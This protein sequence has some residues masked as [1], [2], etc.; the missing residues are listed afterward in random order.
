MTV[1]ALL[2]VFQ[3]LMAQR[4]Q[5]DPAIQTVLQFLST[6]FQLVLATN[7]GS[8]IQRAKLRKAELEPFFPPKAIFISG[9]M[10]S[11]KPNPAFFQTIIQQ[12]QLNAASTLVIG[13]NLIHDIM[14]P[15][16]CGMLTC[17]VS[18]GRETEGGIKPNKVITNITEIS[19]WSRQ[20][21]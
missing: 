11:E 13:D 8:H 1:P 12:L 6:Q 18:H 4:I 14:A 16:L 2:M 7:G 19:K 10:K 15:G 20:L 21:T 9:E 17:W 3:V 5:P